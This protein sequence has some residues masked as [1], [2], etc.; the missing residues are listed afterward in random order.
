MLADSRCA[1]AGGRP[2]GARDE[3]PCRHGCRSRLDD[4]PARRRVAAPT[5]RRPRD[6]APGGRWRTSSTRPVRP[7]RPKGVAVTH[8]GAGQLRGLG[9]GPARARPARGAV[10]AAAAAGDRP[11]QHRGLHQPGHRRRAARSCDAG[12]VTDPAAVRRLPGRAPD[13]PPEGGAVAP[14][15]ARP[16]P[17]DRGGVL[18]A[19]RWCSAARRCTGRAGCGE[20]VAAAGRA[21]RCSTTT[22]RPRR[23]SASPTALDRGRRRPAAGPDRHAD[24]RTPALYVLDERLRPVPPGVAGELYVAGAGLARGYVGRPG[25]TAERF[26][27]CPFGPGERMYRTGDLA[28]WTADGQL[29][30]VGRADDQVKIRG[31]RVEPGEVEAVLART[32]GRRRPR[33]SPGEDDAGDKRLVAYVVARRRHRG[34]GRRTGSRAEVRRRSGCR[35]TWCR[36]RWSCWPRCR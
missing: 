1:L 21:S 27:A 19:G 6:A 18:P 8:G 16:R 17:A 23:P 29:V 33:S 5:A 15:R 2:R 22:V 30:F 14:G 28:R 13:R 4:P 12:A 24:R 31:F 25:L 10:R 35:T 32:R 11:R 9:A 20:L 26:V 3:L 34:R 7:A 36:P